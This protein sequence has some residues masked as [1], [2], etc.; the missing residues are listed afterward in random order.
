MYLTSTSPLRIQLDSIFFFFF[1]A[2]SKFFLCMYIVKKR[3]YIGWVLPLGRPDTSK[4]TT[5]MSKAIQRSPVRS[6]DDAAIMR[7]MVITYKSHHHI[8]V[9]KFLAS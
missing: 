8:R 4:R 9:F 7:N 1:A 6:T 5:V 2:P 3:N